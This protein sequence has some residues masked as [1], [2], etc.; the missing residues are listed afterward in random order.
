MTVAW[1]ES[2]SSSLITPPL[3][4]MLHVSGSLVEEIERVIERSPKDIYVGEFLGL[5]VTHDY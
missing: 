3:S 1:S 5:F 4:N 2:F